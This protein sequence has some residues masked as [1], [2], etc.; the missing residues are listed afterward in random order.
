MAGLMDFLIGTEAKQSSN[1]NNQ[2]QDVWGQLMNAIQSMGGQGNIMGNQAY[3][4]G[5]DYFNSLFNDPS[6]FQNMEAPAM[7]QFNEQTIPDIANRFAGAGS[8][9]STNSTGFRNA[10]LR[11][12]QNLSS[13]L[14][15]QRG[16]MQA[17]A[18]PQ[19][20]QYAQ[21]PTSNLMNMYGM[22]TGQG[23]NNQYMPASPGLAQ[24]AAQGLGK[25]AG[26]YMFGG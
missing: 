4:Q 3:G 20:L 26:N 12:G 9:G 8:A 18:V 16:Q 7:R 21:Q 14:A 13:N 24:Y 15:A 25:A 19:M 10:L 1:Y 5:M 23:I 2:Q 6:F 17:N 22:A 11:E